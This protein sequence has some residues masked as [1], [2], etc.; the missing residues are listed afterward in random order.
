M[1]FNRGLGIGVEY[2]VAEAR[3]LEH[4]CLLLPS[5]KVSGIPNSKTN[6]G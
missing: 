2:K 1:G 5:G 6:H 4:S 3:K